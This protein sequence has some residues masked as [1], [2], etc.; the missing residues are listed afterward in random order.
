MLHLLS[1]WVVCA[2]W[3]GEQ[4]CFQRSYRISFFLNVAEAHLHLEIVT[5]V[6]TAESTPSQTREH[7][8]QHSLKVN[9]DGIVPRDA[10]EVNS[11]YRSVF[12]LISAQPK[13]LVTGDRFASQK[14][15]TWHSELDT[16]ILRGEFQSVS[17]WANTWSP[18]GR[19][20]E[21][22]FHSLCSFDVWLL[23]VNSG[24]DF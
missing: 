19:D 17:Y 16:D 20:D 8:K 3:W 7:W 15:T 12:Q 2:I 4:L 9:P 14:N 10:A 18:T 1:L 23:N 21:Q 24:R 11:S 13:A 22:H 6:R 5:C